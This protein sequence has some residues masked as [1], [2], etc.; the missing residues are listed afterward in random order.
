[1]T[2]KKLVAM[3]LACIMVAGLGASALTLDVAE[4]ADMATVA[5]EAVLAADADTWDGTADTTW[6]N[7][8]DTEFTLTTAEQ[9]AGLAEL[10]DGGDTFEGKTVKLGNDIDLYC[11]DDNGELVS[12]DPIGYGYNIVFKGT[13][14]GQY[15]TI[16]NLYQNGWALGYSYGT[17]GGGLFA[18]AVDANFKNLTIDNAEVIME[19][20]DMGILVGYSYGNCTYE[21]ITVKNSLIA[22][23]Q[24][25][26]GGVVGEVNGTHTFRN[27]DVIDTTVGSLWG[28][29]DASLGGIIGGKYGD[30]TVTLEDC[31][32]SAIIDAY[33]DVISSYQWYAYRRAGMLIGNTEDTIKVGGT[34]YADASFMTATNCTV[35]YDRWANYTYCEFAGTSWPYVRV[36]VG[37]N[38]DAYSN[39]RYGHPKD[40]NGNEVVDDNHVHNAGEDH[41]I[42]CEFRQLYGGGQGVYGTETHEGVTII[43]KSIVAIVDGEEYSTLA[44]AVENA[45][46]GEVVH[47][48][49]DISDENVTIDKNI[50]ITLADAVTFDDEDD[51]VTLTNVVLTVENGVNFALDGLTIRGLSYIYAKTP[52]SLSVTNCD[53]DVTTVEVSGTNCPPSF[54][55]FSSSNGGNVEFTFANNTLLAS[56]DATEDWYTYSHG[57]AGWNAIESAT[58]TNNTF[59]S[60]TLPL[61]AAAVKLMNFVDGAAVT[62]SG[63]TFYVNSKDSTWGPNAFQLFQNNTRAN[64]YTATISGNDFYVD[65]ATAAIGI[66]NNAMGKPVEYAGGA[67]VAVAANNTVNG[68]AINIDDVI[69]FGNGINDL[70]YTRGYVGV[71]VAF[72]EDGK[73]TA[74]I[75]SEYSLGLDA[76]LAEGYVAVTNGAGK[77]VVVPEALI[78]DEVAVVFDNPAAEEGAVTYDIV[79]KATDK[80]INRLNTADLTF[81]IDSDK[82]AYV[83]TAADGIALTNE[84][85]TDRY[86]FN[87]DGKPEGVEDTAEEITIGSVKF[88][89]YDTFT[90]GVVSADTN[91]VTATTLFDNIVDYFDPD[92]KLDDGTEV[93]I[94]DLDDATT[95]EVTIAV[96]TRALT[97]DIA[98]PN[99]VETKIAAYQAMTVTIVGGTVNETIA[100]G[101]DA[102]GFN[103]TRDLPYNTTYNV[104]VTGAG[105]RTARYAVTLTEDKTVNFWNNVKDNDTAMEVSATA[106]KGETTKNFLA[107]DIVGD[108]QIN[109]YD[110][111]AVVSYF[112]TSTSA[113][114][115]KYTKYDLNRDGKIDSKDVA[116]VLV[117][118]G[119]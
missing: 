102:E 113:D 23:Y 91:L 104:T 24:R 105:Y 21:D 112:A 108:N 111:S 7:E 10:V 106:T 97:I 75:F 49:N 43:D 103:F 96:P 52:K 61:G 89:G 37:A 33:N 79:V 62:V 4:S 58:I 1:M 42:L 2:F 67:Y 16:S 114:Y 18:S 53:I 99:A 110:L 29:F 68:Q 11:E 26:T 74:G 118:W 38:N 100:L 82:I 25:Y 3:M 39:P 13:F 47:I 54:V 60:E 117:S 107:G 95:G 84:A 15:H 72:D 32:V 70:S 17:Q 66:N 27:V 92:G 48:I 28:D 14:D 101:S 59:G 31:D 9:L 41:F 35:T 98:F 19:C 64:D 65:E 71:G 78:V 57:I 55:L 63:N 88:T 81:A 69:V 93:G 34:T 20:V 80:I 50:T 77:L 83:I 6:Y 46:A 5:E 30:A 115:E 76:N 51:D 56:P 90:F 94:L 8:T 12:F 119:E 44:A 73:I 40:A 87:F 22:N 109:I 85:G 45:E 36:Q 86:M 116:Y